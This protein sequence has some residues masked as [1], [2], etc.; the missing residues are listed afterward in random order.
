VIDR[1]GYSAISFDNFG[2]SQAVLFI[3]LN[4]S[5][6]HIQDQALSIARDRT[7]PLYI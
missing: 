5:N 2:P 7:V 6:I 3:C 4:P 1:V